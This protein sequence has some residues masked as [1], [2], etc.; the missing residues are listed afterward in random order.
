MKLVSFW[1]DGRDSVGL[2]RDD[3]VVDISSLNGHSYASLRG[4]LANGGIAALEAAA[5]DSL[6]AVPLAQI[7]FRPRPQAAGQKA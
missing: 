6:P 3:H 5:L 7:R 1:R 2:L 4:L